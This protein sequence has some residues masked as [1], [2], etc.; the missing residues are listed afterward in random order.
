MIK[1]DRITISSWRSELD[2][3][4]PDRLDIESTASADSP[5]F[6]PQAQ[7]VGTES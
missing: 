5:P 4:I 6:S 1:R 2:P 3:K 7:S